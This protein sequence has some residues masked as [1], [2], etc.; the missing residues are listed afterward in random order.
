[1]KPKPV[2]VSPP[3]L[4]QSGSKRERVSSLFS[5]SDNSLYSSRRAPAPQAGGLPDH[6]WGLARRSAWAWDVCTRGGAVVSA[7]V[8]S[9]GA[10]WSSVWLAGLSCLRRLCVLGRETQVEA[11][12][13]SWSPLSFSW[14]GIVVKTRG[15]ESAVFGHALDPAVHPSGR[16]SCGRHLPFPS[17]ACE[18]RGRRV[19]DARGADG[20]LSVPATCPCVEA[21]SL[22]SCDGSLS[23]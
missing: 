4:S 7:A 21:P 9:V 15:L 2:S 10:P 6:R 11:C 16:Q 5:H 20:L 3:G 13:S 14:P 23:K 17:W 1:M 12:F 18:A 22:W 8:N 19:R